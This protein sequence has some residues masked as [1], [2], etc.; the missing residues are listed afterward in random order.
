MK[1][2]VNKKKIQRILRIM[3]TIGDGFTYDEQTDCLLQNGERKWVGF[4]QDFTQYWHASIAEMMKCDV[5]IEA[6]LKPFDA[7]YTLKVSNILYGATP[8]ALE[9]V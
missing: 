8:I 7:D 9:I 1:A 3:N 6:L 5:G 4:Y 2:K